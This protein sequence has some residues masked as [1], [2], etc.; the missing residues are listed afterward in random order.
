MT[1][2]HLLDEPTT[3][4][5][6]LA[7]RLA[8]VVAAALLLGFPGGI[9]AIAVLGWSV[10]G[11]PTRVRVLALAGLVVVAVTVSWL[12]AGVP[13][14]QQVGGFTNLGGRGWLDA[15]ARAALG[16]AAGAACLPAAGRAAADW[17]PTTAGREPTA[18]RQS[19]AG[20]EAAAGTEAAAATEMAAG[21][22]PAAGTEPTATTEAASTVSPRPRFPEVDRMRAVAI[23]A[24]VFIH[25]LPFRAPI[26]DYLDYWLSDL[27]RFAVP[28]LLVLAGWLVPMHAVGGRWVR[29]RLGRLLPAYLIA[30]TCMIV[31]A[32]LT[33]AIDARPILGSILFGDAVGPYYFIPVL[34]LLVVLTPVFTRLPTR[35]LVGLTI[36]AAAGSL[37]IEVADLSLYAHNHLPLT[38]LPWYLV[39]MAARPHRERLVALAPTW[40][41]PAVLVATTVALLLA[42]P[43]IETTPRRILTWVA[44]WTTVSALG[45]VSMRGQHP[46]SAATGAISRSS[47]VIYLYHPPVMAGLTGLFGSAIVTMRP[48]TATGVAVVLGVMATSLAVLALSPRGARWFGATS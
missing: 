18:G 43:D 11:R 35:V 5:P 42:F 29:R 1:T 37:A 4:A 15:M 10:F 8:I 2:T 38:W 21:T 41:L 20:L 25:G 40:W 6:S 17:L 24:V 9:A 30:A 3:D 23:V 13:T 47:Y 44:M 28:T 27:T 46:V 12:A 34:V 26:T 19:T 16:I 31:L 7:A 22:Q 32:R 14:P 39:G 33:P 36:L 45:L 48:L